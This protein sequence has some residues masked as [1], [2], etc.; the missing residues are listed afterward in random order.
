MNNYDMNDCAKDP[1]QL[2]ELHKFKDY[3]K[4]LLT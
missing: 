4:N 2:A 1:D 3:K